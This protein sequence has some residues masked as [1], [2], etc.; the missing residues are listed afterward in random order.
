[1]TKD[2]FI[3]QATSLGYCS[4][5]VAIL[6]AG[7]RESFTE[8]DFIKV[9]RVAERRETRKKSIEHG[10]RKRPLGHGCRTTKQYTVY[11]GHYDASNITNDFCKQFT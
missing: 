4:K 11:N 3:S 5:P 8:D 2:K 6:F 7:E 1:M 9:F 10:V